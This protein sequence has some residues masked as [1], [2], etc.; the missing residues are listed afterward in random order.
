M[1]C[2]LRDPMFSRFSRTPTYERQTGRQTQ[3]RSIYRARIASRGKNIHIC[4]PLLA[5]QNAL[6]RLGEI[7]SSEISNLEFQIFSGVKEGDKRGRG[8]GG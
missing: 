5:C 3:G 8:T 1:Q 2:C 7:T 6:R 4:Q